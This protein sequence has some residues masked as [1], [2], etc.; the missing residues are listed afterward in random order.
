MF[1]EGI[2][3]VSHLELGS[4]TWTL[5]DVDHKYLGS[6]EMWG[7]RATKRS[8]GHFPRQNVAHYRESKRYNKNN[9]GNLIGQILHFGTDF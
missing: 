9:K 5:P 7:C 2:N 8:V 1:K 6:L 4:E 3:I